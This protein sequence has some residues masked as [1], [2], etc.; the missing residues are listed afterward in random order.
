MVSII[1]YGMGNLGSVKRKLDL[2]G[3][4]AVITSKSE[5]IRRS[6]KIIL[7]GVGHFARAMA[8]IRKRGLF[9]VLNEE[10]HEKRKPLLGICLGMQLLAKRSEEGEAEGFGWIDANVVRLQITDSLRFKIPHMG[11]N[12]LDWKK[13]SNLSAGLESES[14]FYFVHS[15]HFKCDD[16]SDILATTT[17]ESEFVSAVQKGNIYGT[18]FHPEKSHEAGERMIRNFLGLNIDD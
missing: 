6:E 2:I 18:Q 15:Y 12:T 4:E 3:A 13:G 14:Q 10:V 1:D 5:D 16:P 8:E 7:P 9:D 17:Y 11:W